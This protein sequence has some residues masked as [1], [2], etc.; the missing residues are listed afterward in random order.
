[1]TLIRCISRLRNCGVFRIFDWPGDLP[2]FGR[3]NLI[4]G[5][6]G[7]GKTTLSRVL[8]HLEKRTTPQGEVRLK[9]SSGEFEGNEFPN[10][11][12]PVRVFNRDFVNESV[13]RKDGG[14]LP[15]IFVFGAESVEKQKEVE[16]LRSQRDQ[17]QACVNTL[18]SEK[19]RAEKELNQFCIE[20]ARR[21]KDVL[22]SS[23]QNPYN[24]YNKSDFKRDAK[25]MAKGGDGS[26]HLLSDEEREKLL[27]QHRA[28]P[29]AKVQKV[30]Y[31][32]PNLR[33]MADKVS[34][35]LNTTVVSATIETL[36]NDSNL[37]KWTREGLELHR[38]RKAERCLFCEQ[39]LP[40]ERLAALEAHFND[41]YEQLMQRLDRFIAELQALSRATTELRL[42]H[43]AEFYDDL[44]TE[45]QAAEEGLRQVLEEVKDF[46]DAAVKALMEKKGRPFERVECE[47][48][49]PSVDGEA[50]E[51]LNAV[52]RKHNQAC[53]DFQTRV[54]NARK[55][56]AEHMIAEVLGE[57]VSRRDALEKA[58]KKLKAAQEDLQFLDEKIAALEREIVEHR[59]PAEELNEELRKYLGHDELRL[60]VRDTG[61]IITRGG[62][63]AQSLSEGEMTAIA[64]LYFLKSLQD[65]QFD[66]RNGVVVLDD[67]VSSLDANALYLAFGFI[68]ERTKDVGQLIILTHNFTFFRQVRNWFHHLPNQKKKDISRRPA[69]FYMLNCVRDGDQRYATI[70][71]LDPLLE[72]YE[73]EYHYLFAC[74]YRAASSDTPGTLEQNYSL[75]NMARRLLESFLAFRRPAG[76]LREKMKSIDFDER[77]KSRILSFVHTYSHSNTIG[78]P[79][80]DPSLLTEAKSVLKDLLELIQSEDKAHY[81]AMVKLVKLQTGEEGEE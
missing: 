16:H 19:Q 35:L 5:W 81:D 63:P 76:D 13:F 58:E 22:R 69:R 43:K 15:P 62:V 54:T 71:Q 9:L 29:K 2:E 41:Q 56:L 61:Y 23:G 65:K 44:Q 33:E 72:E 68:R 27:G 57:F 47:L 48:S 42:P 64:L 28:T 38:H 25:R 20:H 79:E 66:L 26:A 12:I 75:P 6:N 78:E 4:Y 74:I 8:R 52:I 70:C 14:E 37:S 30:K 50:L 73:S 80:H 51:K 34:Q 1:M 11:D 53:D 46:L 59:R 32:L 40:K 67:P 36:K 55:R 24:D 49:V 18:S 7:T 45:Y 3:F 10:L 77:R 31:T 60:E 39:L 21:I 17:A